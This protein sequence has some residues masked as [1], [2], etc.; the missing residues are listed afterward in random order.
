M[1]ITKMNSFAV[2]CSVF[3]PTWEKIKIKTP[4]DL[5]V[6][7]GHT[8]PIHMYLNHFNEVKENK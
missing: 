1:T 4:Y 5:D 7:V 3:F 2:F 8:V 6:I